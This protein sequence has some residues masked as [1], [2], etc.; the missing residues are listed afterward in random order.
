MRLAKSGEGKKKKES[1]KRFHG[2]RLSLKGSKKGRGMKM[3]LS[4]RNDFLLKND[5]DSTMLVPLPCPERA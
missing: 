2:R 3:D 4:G 1:E 5:L